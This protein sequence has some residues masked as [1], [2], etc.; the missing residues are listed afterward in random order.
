MNLTRMS[1][2]NHRM[3]ECGT[4]A[5]INRMY[6]TGVLAGCAIY[7]LITA[8]RK[9]ANWNVSHILVSKIYLGTRS[10]VAHILKIND[11]NVLVRGCR[12]SSDRYITVDRQLVSYVYTRIS[13]WNHFRIPTLKC[14][15]QKNVWY[16]CFIR[17]KDKII[18]NNF[19][20]LWKYIQVRKG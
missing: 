13:N 11:N 19:F 1:Y 17:P 6:N 18:W 10:G 9:S 16:S 12:T 14:I 7:G 15:F 3:T 5:L 4:H 20:H 8:Y 2:T